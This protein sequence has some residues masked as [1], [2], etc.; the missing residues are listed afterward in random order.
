MW[1][2]CRRDVVNTPRNEVVY[3]KFSIKIRF[4][5]VYNTNVVPLC[6]RCGKIPHVTRSYIAN[7]LM[8]IRFLSV[9]EYKCGPPCRQNVVKYARR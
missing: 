9:Y 4:L 2:P 3:S 8:K 1:S 7:S 5:G 6:A